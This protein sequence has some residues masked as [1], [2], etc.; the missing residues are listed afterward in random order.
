MTRSMTFIWPVML[1]SLLLIPL[2]VVFYLLL[3]RRRQKRA[4][5]YSSFGF[6]QGTDGRKVGARR[7]IPPVLFL[8]GLVVMLL[9]MAR[10]QATVRLP[11][12]EG[13]VI[14]AFDVS[15]SM[16]AT[17]MEPSRMEVAKTAARD[18][19]QR[20]SSSVQIGVVAF[21]DGGFTVQTPTNDQEAILTAIDRLSPQRG[22]S[23]G[24][25]ILVSLNAITQTDGSSPPSLIVPTPGPNATP[26]P[27]PTI[28]YN[29][30]AIILLTDGENTSNPDP[31]TAA[32]T[33]AQMGVRIYT[34]GIG[35]PNGIDLQVNGFTVHT[36]LDEQM[37]QRISTI[38]GGKYFKAEN[39]EQLRSIYKNIEP[40]F[41]VKSQKMEITSILAGIS[42]LVLLVGAVF[43]LLWFGHLP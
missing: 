38:A 29:S 34:I 27:L 25:G 13:T 33:A 24:Q 14:L 4:V 42:I 3:Q 43:S 17:D 7:H 20:Q 11:T 2:F 39:E 19:V 10:P 1:F 30:A 22:T 35:S 23:I 36:Q 15:G 16:A 21:S 32:D 5:D 8:S 40:Q 28:P 6:A 18:F 31:L 9:A 37:L 26:T 41:K 12:V